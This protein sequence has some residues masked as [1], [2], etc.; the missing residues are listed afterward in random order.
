RLLQVGEELAVSLGIELGGDVV[1]EEEGLIPEMIAEVFDLGDL[2]AEDHRAL[3]ALG[4]EGAGL[5][6][7]EFEVQAIGVGAHP[8]VPPGAI[9][10]EAGAEGAEEGLADLGLVGPGRGEAGAV[11][12]AAL[13]LTAGEGGKGLAEARLEF[14]EELAPPHH[15]PRSGLGQGAVEGLHHLR[16]SLLPEETISR[17]EGARI[18]AAFPEEGRE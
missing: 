5:A 11:A 3:L 14:G 1:Q 10:L 6:A 13:E 16:G 17:A 4:G 9:A 2:P 15:D 12:K 7:E 8:G 18:G